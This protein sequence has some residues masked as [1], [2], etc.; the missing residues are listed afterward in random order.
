MIKLIHNRIFTGIMTLVIALEIFLF[1]TIK[2]NAG[3]NTGIN[4]ALFYHLGIFFVFTFFL[5]L[6]LEREEK[7]KTKH[8]IWT[9]IIALIYAIS[10]E[11][12]QLFVQG[13]VASIKDVFIDLIG[14]TTA[15]ILNL[16]IKIKN[17]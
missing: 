17:K 16:I 6:T 11:I 3:A 2:T 13:R 4:L 7:I 12:H 15:I 9:L 10:D 8:I 1:S 14:I 5:F